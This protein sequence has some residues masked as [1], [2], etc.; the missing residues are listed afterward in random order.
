[1]LDIFR[2]STFGSL[3]NTV[4]KGRLLP[5]PDQTPGWKPPDNLRIARND[6]KTLDDNAGGELSTEG[7]KDIGSSAS[8][9]TPFSL[10]SSNAGEVEEGGSKN[11]IGWYDDNDQENPMYEMRLLCSCFMLIYCQELVAR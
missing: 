10:I 11:I 1:M 5:H 2:D 4:S 9:E 3:L 7:V 8:R 6:E